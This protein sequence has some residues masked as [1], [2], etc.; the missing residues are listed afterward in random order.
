MYFDENGDWTIELYF[1]YYD[2]EKDTGY[3]M[4]T[5]TDTAYFKKFPDSTNFLLL[6][7]AD[8][9]H[10]ISI[11]KAG[12][13]IWFE[14]WVYEFEM[15]LSPPFIFG[16]FPESGVNS[17]YSGQSLVSV[18]TQV[19]KD[20]AS[21]IGF[22]RDPAK[23]ILQGHIYD[24]VGTPL[25]NM[26][27]HIEGFEDNIIWSDENGF[28]GD[29]L[30]AKNYS[31]FVIVNN[32][33][34]RIYDS[35]FTIEPDSTS[36]HNIHLPVSAEIEFSGYCLLA[37]K[38][39]HS[40]TTIYLDPVSPLDVVVTVTTD[41]S[42]YYS[43]TIPIGH[44][45]LRYS[46][47]GYLPYYTVSYVDLFFTLT[48]D[49]ILLEEG[50]V[51]EIGES[52]VSGEWLSDYPYWIFNDIKIMENDTLMINPGA[53]VVF[54]RSRKWDVFGTLL[55]E[56]TEE[57]SIKIHYNNYS[58][59]GPLNFWYEGSG[60]SKIKYCDIKSQEAYNFYNSSPSIEKSL[61]TW[62]GSLN[63]F[64]SAS[65]LISEC[66][67]NHSI[68]FICYDSSA[69]IISRSVLH[70]SIRCFD[71]STPQIVN[72]D[73]HSFWIGIDCYGNA[74]PEIN[75][76]IFTSGSYAIDMRFG[77]APT[78]CEYNIFYDLYDPPIWTYDEWIPSFGELNT[79]NVNGDSC[80]IYFNLFMD[81]LLKDPENG[82]FSL[83]SDS[84][85]IDA[86]NPDFP[87]DPD[88]TI[89]DMGAFYFNQTGVSIQT[90]EQQAS[91]V[92]LFHY[93]NPA[94]NRIYFVIEGNTFRNLNNAR[95]KIYDMSGNMVGELPCPFI[96]KG[97][98]KK[99]FQYQ[100]DEKNSL[101]PGTY[102]YILEADGQLLSTNKMVL[103]K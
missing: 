58:A 77:K 79:T 35:I 60:N 40:N 37:G 29:T 47:Q 33:R 78:V 42:G 95:I 76:N 68:Y 100:F 44:Y 74:D 3:V 27:I 8:L 14:D 5:S 54:K 67:F 61:I 45:Y 30:Y 87:F 91:E 25:P 66:Y 13:V 101:K 96:E 36:I 21:S 88:T 22:M 41:S 98:G 18:S 15:P 89:A 65:P 28:F 19:V 38:D 6:T 7:K 46:Q 56:G 26:R 24:S 82:G 16:D 75:G 17:P 31:I 81:P 50:N 1:D 2:V 85:C 23:G 53:E 102:I 64:N 73:F 63:F 71:Y 86:G 62:N 20:T 83:L 93:P 57:D 52:P 51:H 94:S 72:N 11:N 90:W 84:P 59:W 103:L 70:E 12:N 32:N 10:P 80:D 48:M 49:D 69:P 92:K 99:V 34:Y 39:D 97:F 55:A 9:D 4:I 43:K